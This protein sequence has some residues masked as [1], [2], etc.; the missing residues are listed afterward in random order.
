MADKKTWDN[1]F[2][3]MAKL[4]G[5]WSTCIRENRQVGAVIVKDRRV[6][7]TGYN[8]SP[9]GVASCVERG[10]CIRDKL[11]IKSGSHQELCYGVHAEQNAVAQAAKL[12]HSIEGSTIYITHSPCSVC[13]RILINAGVKRI[14]FLNNYPDD[15]SLKILEE[16]NIK[17]EQ[18]KSKK[19]SKK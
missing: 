4:V 15:F 8:G 10:F 1:R 13:S 11:K 6:L 16:A 18:L 9:A 17:F 14:V 12:G 19:V 3:D 2:M 5:S 7:A